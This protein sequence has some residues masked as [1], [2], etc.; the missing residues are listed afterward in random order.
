M[1]KVTSR[2]GAKMVTEGGDVLAAEDVQ[3]L[4]VEA[5]AGYDLSHA[6]RQLG[7]PSLG[8]GVSPRVSFRTS[9]T[10]YQAARERA[11]SEGRSV[12]ELARE[13]MERYVVHPA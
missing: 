10:L 2:R 13:A 1:A 9:V 7:R 6:R 8:S 3:A 12:S 11:A 5:E 4:A